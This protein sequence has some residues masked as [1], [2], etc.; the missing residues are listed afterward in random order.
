MRNAC[1]GAV[2]ACRARNTAR[3]RM[4]GGRPVDR[5]VLTGRIHGPWCSGVARFQAQAEE[6]VSGG[7]VA[8]RHGRGVAALW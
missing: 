2:T 8:D 3:V 7:V 5:K 4:G 1:S 6:G